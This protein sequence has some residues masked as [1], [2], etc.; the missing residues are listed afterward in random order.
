VDGAGREDADVLNVREGVSERAARYD[1]WFAT[2]L[3][4]AMDTAE[5][6]AVLGL[7]APR[8]GEHALDAGCGT[9]LYTRRLLDRGAIVTGVDQDPEMLAAARLKAPSATLIQAQITALPFESASFDLTLAVTL[10]CFAE[11]P[12][13]AVS[14]LARVTRPGGRV[15]L[16]ELGRYS[17]WAARRRI[18][19][20][21]GSATWAHVRFY[22]PGELGSLLRRAGARQIRTSAAA[23]LPPG[24]PAWLIKRAASYERRAQRLSAVGAAFSLARGEISP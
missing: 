22:T 12:Q 2:P 6:R 14:E 4:Q 8:P 3:G 10:L 21:R 18:Q 23:Y 16:A 15:A 24:A 1:A 20:W 9:G 17:L 11:D 19:G 7:A 13:R 5:A